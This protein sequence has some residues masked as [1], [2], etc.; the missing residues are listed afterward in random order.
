MLSYDAKLTFIEKQDRDKY[1]MEHPDFIETKQRLLPVS[2]VI[3]ETP[4]KKDN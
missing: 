2:K 1:L 3:D 4:G